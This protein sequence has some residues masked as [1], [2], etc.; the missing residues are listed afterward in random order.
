LPGD[1]GQAGRKPSQIQPITTATACR[2]PEVSGETE[3]AL[4]D[5]ILLI[6]S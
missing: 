1:Q 4:A 2:Q 5:R 3:A 6:A